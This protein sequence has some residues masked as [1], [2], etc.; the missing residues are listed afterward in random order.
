MRKLN[1]IWLK[2]IFILCSYLMTNCSSDDHIANSI[3]VDDNLNETVN[4]YV[5]N[6]V[7]D[8]SVKIEDKSGFLGWKNFRDYF[9]LGNEGFKERIHQ[10]WGDVYDNES[11]EL[12]INSDLSIKGLNKTVKLQKGFSYIDNYTRTLL[13]PFLT[14]AFEE[15]I[16]WLI[17]FLAIHFLII[18]YW[19]KNTEKKKVEFNNTGSFWKDLG[20]FALSSFSEGYSYNQRLKQNIAISKA[21][22]RKRL[23]WFSIFA[24]I[25]LVDF[26]SVLNKSLKESI[27]KDIIVEIK[28][29]INQR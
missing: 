16:V 26:N 17:L 15:L 12:A 10:T 4:I 14:I 9:G 6:A 29:Q 3:H 22:W 5:N 18:P 1:N 27:K 11:L 25:F 13:F 2:S 8:F 20:L 28:E 19:V 23:F 21:K 7:D 24:F